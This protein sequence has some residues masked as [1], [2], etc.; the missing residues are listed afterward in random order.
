MTWKNTNDTTQG[1]IWSIQGWVLFEY[2]CCIILH[3]V[4]IRKGINFLRVTRGSLGYLM[5]ATSNICDFVQK[6]HS[7]LEGTFLCSYILSSIATYICIMYPNFRKAFLFWYELSFVLDVLWKF[8]ASTHALSAEMMYFFNVY[9]IRLAMKIVKSF[10][11]KI[12]ESY[13]FLSHFI[14]IHYDSK[15]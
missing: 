1:S 3:F 6:N 8:F 14:H 2:I 4:A 9:A 13:C 7:P 15:H 11:L 10:C 5:H 12:K